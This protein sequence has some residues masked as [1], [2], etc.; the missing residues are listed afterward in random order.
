MISFVSNVDFEKSNQ[1]LAVSVGHSSK[2]YLHNKLLYNFDNSVREIHLGWHHYFLHS[3]IKSGESYIWKVPNLP[4]SR[5]RSIVAKCIL[6]SENQLKSD[7]K[8]LPYAIGYYSGREFNQDGIYTDDQSGIEYGMT[9]ATFILTLFKSVGIELLDRQQWIY[10]NDDKPWFDYI[11]SHLE[12]GFANGK[13]SKKHLDNVK[14]EF[15]CSR[16]RPEEVFGSLFCSNNPSSFECS[17]TFGYVVRSF[18][19]G[20]P[21]EY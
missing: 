3:E 2:G 5:L 1:I 19:I 13:V 17:S 18:V 14:N 4:K 9:C 10:R 21:S 16:Y 7:K 8:P 12:T 15:N 20:L 11:I 6:V